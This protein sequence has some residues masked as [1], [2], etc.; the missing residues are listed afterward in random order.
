MSLFIYIG[1]MKTRQPIFYHF[2]KSFCPYDN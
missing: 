2:L 1:T